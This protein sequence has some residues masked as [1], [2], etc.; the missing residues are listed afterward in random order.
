VGEI[1]KRFGLY[2]KYTEGKTL[3]EWIKTGFDGSGVEKAGICSWEQMQEKRYCVV[4]T[5]PDWEKI[6][7]GMIEFYEDPEKCP[8]STPSGKLEYYSERLAKA[9]PDDIERPPVPHWVEKSDFHDERI[10][11]I[12]AKEYPLLVISN[13]PRWRVHAQMDDINWFH[14]IPTGKVIGPD[15]YH[16]E[17]VW[18]NP[19][20]AEK[21]GIAS[22]DVV[23]VYN[24]RGQVLCG[25]YVTERIMPGVIY[26]D[27]GSRYDPIVA[28]EIDRGGAINTI[29]PHHTTSKNCA[30]MVTSG[31]LAEAKKADMDGLR[32]Q[33]P[34]A[35]KRPYDKGSGQKFERVLAK[36]DK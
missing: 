2:E 1:A 35:F 36:G 30:G 13:H 10:S 17:P 12:R 18:I 25:A 22:G 14:E 5:D 33:Y 21:R 7:H 32:Q 24:E 4:P 29:C 16:Y 3:Q 15:K 9:F 26:V 6:P 27:H 20:D 8:M 28:G 23:N 31:F 11:S 34:E 19:I